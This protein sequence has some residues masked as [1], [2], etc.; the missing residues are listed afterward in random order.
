M[1]DSCH[2]SSFDLTNRTSDISMAMLSCNV[3]DKSCQRYICATLASNLLKYAADLFISMLSSLRTCLMLLFDL[4]SALQ[5]L[6]I[7]LDV[8][9]ANWVNWDRIASV[10]LS[11]A[12]WFVCN[13]SMFFCSA[14]TC[15]S[16]AKP[17]MAW[18]AGVRND[19]RALFSWEMILNSVRLKYF[20]QSKIGSIKVLP[21]SLIQRCSMSIVTTG[22][23]P[24][25]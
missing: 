6:S 20:Y 14:A 15:S 1:T 18:K 22:S 12:N 21:H 24:L 4:S 2:T 10:L 7:R 23:M 19:K 16:L 9:L 11:S 25:F 3:V 13:I 5:I 17:K 8:I